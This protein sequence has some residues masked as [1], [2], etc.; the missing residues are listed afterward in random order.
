[1]DI[2]KLNEMIKQLEEEK[3]KSINELKD[4]IEVLKREQIELANKK[5]KEKEINETIKQCKVRKYKALLEKDNECFKDYK[6]K[7]K[8]I[9][10]LHEMGEYYFEDMSN[11]DWDNYDIEGDFERNS[12][13]SRCEYCH[14]YSAE[15]GG[16]GDDESFCECFDE[17]YNYG[18]EVF[19]D[20]DSNCEIDYMEHPQIFRV[21]GLLLG[22]LSLHP[23]EDLNNDKRREMIKKLIKEHNIKIHPLFK[24]D[25]FWA[26]DENC[27]IVDDGY[28]ITNYKWFKF[29]NPFYIDEDI[30][31]NDLYELKV[32][33]TVF[34]SKNLLIDRP[35][36][37]TLDECKESIKI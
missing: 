3:N 33:P 20:W 9:N 14:K 32:C 21:I 11:H 12:K 28:F 1:M 22:D 37:D 34:K 35:K 4:K 6:D 19:E 23:Q 25:I 13:K 26:C 15:H 2:T 29:V 18:Y 5:K 27:K 17:W 8:A 16:Y 10:K 30:I 24:H 36:F 31:I 7:I